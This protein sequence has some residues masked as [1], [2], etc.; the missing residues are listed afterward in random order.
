MTYVGEYHTTVVPHT[1]YDTR[2]RPALSPFYF[3]PS[4]LT[5]TVIE[6]IIPPKKR[7]LNSEKSLTNNVP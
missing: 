1:Q 5:S 4:N 2:T 3:F 7:S 6:F